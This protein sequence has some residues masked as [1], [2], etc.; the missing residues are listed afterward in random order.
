[1]PAATKPRKPSRPAAPRA[2]TALHAPPPSLTERYAV[3]RTLRKAVAAL[4]MTRAAA[5]A[6]E[7]AG[8]EFVLPGHWGDSLDIAC[9]CEAVL[10]LF[11][12]PDLLPQ[13]DLGDFEA[14]RHACTPV[15]VEWFLACLGRAELWFKSAGWGVDEFGD[16][17]EWTPATR[18]IIGIGSA[19]GY[20]ESLIE[21]ETV[22][23][24]MKPYEVV[25][26]KILTAVK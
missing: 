9:F 24:E 21:S 23:F 7:N 10:Q 5:L 26:D 14:N 12:T 18:Q 17:T 25:I 19:I 3:N 1:M 2:A 6:V 13:T 20:F 22:Q 8:Q 4:S 11:P 15:A 16:E